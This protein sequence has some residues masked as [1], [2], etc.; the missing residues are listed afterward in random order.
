MQRIATLYIMCLVQRRFDHDR[1]EREY[2]RGASAVNNSSRTCGG[3][4][5]QVSLNLRFNHDVKRRQSKLALFLVST[6]FKSITR[7]C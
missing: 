5:N 7:G 4:V 1:R 3:M 6:D 2:V